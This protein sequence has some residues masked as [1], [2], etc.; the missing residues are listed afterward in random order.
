MRSKPDV[1][2]SLPTNLRF[3]PGGPDQFSRDSI[4]GL[5]LV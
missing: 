2:Y 5:V 1:D 3:C 4:T